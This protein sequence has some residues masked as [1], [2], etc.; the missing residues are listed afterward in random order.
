M[1]KIFS[2]D[3]LKSVNPKDFMTID[4]LKQYK[5]K[6]DKIN[7]KDRKKVRILFIDDGGFDTE[8]LNKL[9]YKDI[10]VEYDFK[11]MNMIESYDIIF[12]DINDV[13]KNIYPTGQGAELASE[14]KRTYPDKYVIIFSAQNQK[15]SF[16]KY[17]EDVDAVIDKTSDQ[18]VFQ[19]VIDQ[20]ISIQNNP[21][22]YWE[23]LEKVMLKQKLNKVYISKLEHYYVSSI[24]DNKNYVKKINE[25]TSNF[26]FEKFATFVGL[27][28]DAVTIFMT[29]FKG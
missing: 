13:A 1:L 25:N 20:Y 6:I 5:N 28:A 2:K 17:Y 23:N 11:N 3:K 19:N 9:G 24:I 26:D 7:I 21:I 22:A 29:F 15:P 27:V 18:R 8:P 16:S 10:D 4:V 12:C 14:I